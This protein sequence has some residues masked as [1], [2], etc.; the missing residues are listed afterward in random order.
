MGI[1]GTVTLN[2]LID[3]DGKVRETRVIQSVYPSL[4][5]AAAKWVIRQRYVPALRDGLPYAEWLEV[6]VKFTIED[7]DESAP[8]TPS[9]CG[10]P[11]G[12]LPPA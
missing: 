7:L 5:E 3:I 11:P 12:C 4:D 10:C 9:S 1:H 2:V 8:T 6:P